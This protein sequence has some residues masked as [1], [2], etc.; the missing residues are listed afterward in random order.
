MKFLVF[1]VETTDLI[2][3]N[4]SFNDTDKWPYIVQIS[5]IIYDNKDNSIETI[6]HIIK[7]PENVIINPRSQ[8]IH[9]YTKEICNTKGVLLSTVLPIINEKINEANIIIAHNISFDKRIYIVECIRNKIPNAFNNKKEYCT[10]KNTTDLCGIKTPCK[11]YPNTYYNK[12]PKLIELYK[13]L[14]HN[15]A[16]NLHNSLT[17]VIICLRCYYMIT[18]NKDLYSEC[19]D[20]K[21]LFDNNQLRTTH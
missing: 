9:G 6:N 4:P 1:D 15:N 2:K 18:Y 20:Y 3:N 14:F 11:N 8:E 16:I 19:Q 5:L 10:M 17:D 7:I 21:T 13:H 12:Y